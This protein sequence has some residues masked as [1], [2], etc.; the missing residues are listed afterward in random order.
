[1]DHK[2][3]S[4]DLEFICLSNEIIE[5]LEKILNK[6]QITLERIVNSNYV[7]RFLINEENE[8]IFSMTKKILSEKDFIYLISSM[9]NEVNGVQIN[10]HSL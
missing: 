3:F 5:N 6:Y 9:N 8:D 7:R 1:M 4:I 10:K 2:I